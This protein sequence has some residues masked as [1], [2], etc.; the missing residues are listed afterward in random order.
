MGGTQSTRK[1]TVEN[2]NTIQV[3]QEALNRIQAQLSSNQSEQIPSS[4]PY[5]PPPAIEHKRHDNAAEEAYWIRRIENLKRAHENINTGMQLE[6]QKTLNEANKLFELTQ[7]DK[8]AIKLPP[9]QME[10]SK[11]LECYN[12]NPGKTLTCSMLVNEFNNCVCRS[13]VAAVSASS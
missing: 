8:V 12:A 4:A 10:K 9:C 2:E 1:V 5:I 6:Y 13:R 3:S 11:V 7:A